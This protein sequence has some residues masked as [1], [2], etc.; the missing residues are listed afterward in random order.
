MEANVGDDFPWQKVKLDLELE[1]KAGNEYSG[2]VNSVG[3]PH[4]FG[5]QS[6]GPNTSWK[7]WRY[8]GTFENGVRSGYGWI[9]YTDGFS[10]Y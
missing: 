4:G 3:V 7:F 1:L 6:K 5:C 2:Q 10:T 8:I 9:E